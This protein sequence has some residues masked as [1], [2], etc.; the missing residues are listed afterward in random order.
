MKRITNFLSNMYNHIY[1]LG[2][3]DTILFSYPESLDQKATESLTDFIVVEIPYSMRSLLISNDGLVSTYAKITFFAKDNAYK[4]S[5]QA[6]YSK[7][8]TMHSKMA[9]S[10]PFITKDFKLTKSNIVIP[11]KKASIHFHY[12]VINAPL[13]FK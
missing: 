2:V 1:D 6:D 9:E 10:L 13:L 12:M 4:G 3:T 8:E 11:P 5:R 7:L